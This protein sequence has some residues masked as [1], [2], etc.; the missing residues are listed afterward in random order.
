MKKVIGVIIS[1]IVIGM[2][3]VFIISPKIEF[4]FNE[5]RYL[6]RFPTITIESVLNGKYMSELENYVS[7]HFTMR[8]FL[9]SFNNKVNRI[10]G[11]YKQSDIYYGKDNKLYQEYKEPINNDVIIKRVNRL[12]DNTNA[13]FYFML[14]PTSIYIYKDNISKY[15]TCYDEGLTMDYFKDNLNVT[16]IDV[17]DKFNSNKNDYLYYG[18]DHHWTTRGA[19]QAYLEYSEVLGIKP[20]KYDYEVVNDKF[21]GTLYSKVLDNS[22]EYDYIEKIIDDTKYKVYY[23][24]NNTYTDSLYN[25][26]YL[27]KKDKYSFFLDNNHSLIKIENL[28]NKSNDSLLIIK[29][30]YANAFV[31]F[32]G[33]N[34][35]YVYIID[36]RYYN[37]SISD[38]INN[39]NINNVLFL[40]NILTIDDDLGIVSIK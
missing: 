3:L 10:M 5:N 23:E 1:V 33:K 17:R 26:D 39:N 19:Y 12:K 36:P 7:D 40:Y 18:T 28:D 13:D 31:P 11:V 8:E 16:F 34:Y 30:S 25:Y 6:T 2:L 4:S 27:D 21:Y 29:D 22:L 15:N 24:D 35:K 32:I 9:L 37:L 20:N 14:V 38:Y